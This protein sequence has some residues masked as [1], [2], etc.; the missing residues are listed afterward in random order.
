M[1]LSWSQKIFLRINQGIG[2]HA[3]LDRLMKFSAQWLLYLYFFVVLAWGVAVLAPQDFKLFIKL[4]LTAFALGNIV[5]WLL[6]F[7]WHHPRP[8]EEL[9]NVKEVVLPMQTFRSFPSLHTM[10][11]FIC[12]FLAILSGAG[13]LAGTMFFIISVV[14]AL[15]RVYVGVHY[16]RDVFGGIFFALFFSLTVFWFLENVSQPVYI[17][18]MSWF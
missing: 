18:L 17:W 4:L 10:M 1:S 2:Q 7:V 5:S 16:P 11:S 3:W 15:S 6:A 9:P 8:I 13:V 12:L 14:V